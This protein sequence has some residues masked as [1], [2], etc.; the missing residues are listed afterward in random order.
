MSPI[1]TLLHI[2]WGP[3]QHRRPTFNRSL[4]AEEEPPL[5]TPLDENALE[6]LLE[7]GEL[8]ANECVPCPAC[9][10][11]TFHAMHIDGSRTCWTCRTTSAGDQ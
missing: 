11:T 4:L 7:E 9:E 10:R 6:Q 8:E 3:G 1:R 5:E 2:V